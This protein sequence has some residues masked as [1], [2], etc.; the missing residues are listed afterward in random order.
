MKAEPAAATPAPA[1]PA[2]ADEPVKLASVVVKGKA[3][4]DAL[5]PVAAGYH[6]Y[7]DASGPWDFT[8][9]QTNIG[10]NNNKWG[11]IAAP[12]AD[13]AAAGSTSSSC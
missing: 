9:N 13:A 8:G 7:T 6:V 1:A 12:A 11:S 5:C 3:A 2:A 10:A 4:V